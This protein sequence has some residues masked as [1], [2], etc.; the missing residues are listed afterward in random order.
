MAECSWSQYTF[1]CYF[2]AVM[3][4][5]HDVECDLHPRILSCIMTQ[6]CNSPSGWLSHG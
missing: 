2:H 5:L 4:D 3:S 1:A 6:A